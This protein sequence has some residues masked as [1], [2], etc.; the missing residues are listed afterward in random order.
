MSEK[1]IITCDRC[2]QEIEQPA[3][4]FGGAAPVRYYI[5]RPVDALPD[6]SRALGFNALFD[7]LCAECKRAFDEWWD[8]GGPR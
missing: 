2:K 3:D 1:R 4:I 8:Y 6:A 5:C 7:D